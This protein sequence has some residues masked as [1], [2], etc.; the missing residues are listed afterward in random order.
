MSRI[1]EALKVWER[2]S[3]SVVAEVD[4]T[5]PDRLLP[6][7]EYESERPASLPL[8]PQ[9]PPPVRTVQPTRAVA[10]PAIRPHDADL[11]ARLVTGNMNPASVEQYRKLAAALHDW[12]VETQAKTV[13]I[14][15]ALPREGRTLTVVNLALT[16]SESYARRVLVIDADLRAPALHTTLDIPNDRGLSEALR[17][18]HPALCYTEVSSRLSALSAGKPDSSP[19]T[20]L[21]SSRMSEILEECASYF[22]WV[23]IDTP[24]VGML[25]DA[26]RLARLVGGI[27]LVIGAR[28]TPAA[29]VAK[30]VAEFG[31]PEA[32][33]GTVLN[34]VE[35]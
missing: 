31:G 5:E 29:A 8:V 15:S 2:V 14:T 19:L 25:P 33:V 17:D 26:Q 35:V 7:R 22:D 13:M 32:I 16:L 18:G 21:T 20:G 34:R 1:D 24:P 11:Q 27:L 4:A 30:A 10:M 9:V 28:S 12:Q 6:F 3:G 23:L